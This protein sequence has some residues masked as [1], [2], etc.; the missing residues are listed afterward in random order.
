MTS[1]QSH[2]WDRERSNPGEAL[3][4]ESHERQEKEPKGH[5][6]APD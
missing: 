3:R 5:L 4:P 2:L 1:C 6:G